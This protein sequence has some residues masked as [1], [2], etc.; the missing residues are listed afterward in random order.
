[1]YTV[2]ANFLVN[3]DFSAFTVFVNFKYIRIMHRADPSHIIMS[4]MY[5]AHVSMFVVTLFRTAFCTKISTPISK[6]RH[7]I[8]FLVCL[9]PYTGTF[10][11]TMV[12]CHTNLFLFL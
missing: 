6:N 10:L 3:C 12:D 7:Y 2:V 11:L 1:M 8:A 9:H 5:V 4:H